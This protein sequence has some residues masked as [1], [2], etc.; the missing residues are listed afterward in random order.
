MNIA[1]TKLD[2]FREDFINQLD[3]TTFAT[4]IACSTSIGLGKFV[5]DFGKIDQGRGIINILLR[6]NLVDKFADLL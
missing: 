3:D 4:I 5:F 2:P 1:G 6:I